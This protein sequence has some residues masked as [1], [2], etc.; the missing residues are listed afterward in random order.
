MIE[1]SSSRPTGREIAESNI[2]TLRNN[3]YPGRGIVVGFNSAGTK[4]IEIYWVMGRS[5]Q[6][7]NRLLALDGDTIKTIPFDASKI[8]DPSL[9]IYNAMRI[10]RG[11]HV[12][13]N[14]DQTDSVV[15]ALLHGEKYDVAL[16]QRTFEPDK[17]NFTSR[18]TG[19]LFPEGQGSHFVLSTI[20]RENAASDEPVHAFYSYDMD[21]LRGFGKVIHTYA[22][23]G[24]PLPSLRRRPYTVP[25]DDNIGDITAKFWGLLNPDNRVAMVAKSVD[26]RTGDAGYRIANKLDPGGLLAGAISI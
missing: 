15:D 12:V 7:R 22:G 21:D 11:A 4:G 13:S 6:S 2:E 8:Q 25:L 18:I 14:G 20:A 10:A 19:I 23:D 17:P 24:T 5:E 26:L 16:M 9:I 1:I 3:P